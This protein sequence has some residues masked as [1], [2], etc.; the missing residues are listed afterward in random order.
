MLYIC[1]MCKHTYTAYIFIYNNKHKYVYMCYIILFGNKK[2]QNAIII[3][4]LDI[5]ALISNVFQRS[6]HMVTYI[7]APFFLM[8]ADYSIVWMCHNL[9]NQSPVDGYLEGFQMFAIISNVA[10]GIL[11]TS[12]I[13]AHISIS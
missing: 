9:A 6:F 13:H 3:C 1:Y 12:Y 5:F 10:M 2:L 7:F 4:F 8:I 11:L